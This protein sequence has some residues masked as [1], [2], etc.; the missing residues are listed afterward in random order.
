MPS[1]SL[2]NLLD[3]SR[4]SNKGSGQ[5][6][7]F[8]GNITDRILDV[9]WDPFN[10]VRRIIVLDIA[11]LLMDFPPRRQSSSE[12][13]RGSEKSSMPGIDS[14]HHVLGI[15]HLLSEFGDCKSSVLF[16]SSGGEG[17]E[18][19]HEEV[20]SWEGDQVHAKLSKI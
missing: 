4:I 10:E 3:G 18:A 1:N 2:E 15:E 13:R 8:G 20:Q 7:S 9:I 14:A 6:E 19:N 5:L 16:R 17:S 11:H 12:N